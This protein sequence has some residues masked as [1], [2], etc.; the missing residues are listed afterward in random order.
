MIYINEGFAPKKQSLF[1]P[2]LLTKTQFEKEKTINKF[3]VYNIN[4]DKTV[5]SF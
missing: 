5:L 3:F 2:H 4:C 1:L